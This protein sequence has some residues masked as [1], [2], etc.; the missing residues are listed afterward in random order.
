M[1]IEIFA[2]IK[3]AYYSST[4]NNNYFADTLAMITWDSEFYAEDEYYFILDDMTLVTP[5]LNP[6]NCNGNLKPRAIFS[7]GSYLEF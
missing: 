5:S 6:F 7:D 1:I 3:E 2:K 4:L